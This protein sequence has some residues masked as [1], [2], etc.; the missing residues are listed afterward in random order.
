M[1]KKNPEQDCLTCR[2]RWRRLNLIVPRVAIINLGTRWNEKTAD[3]RHFQ[4][5][6]NQNHLT[7]Y[8]TSSTSHIAPESDK[9]PILGV[10]VL[11]FS[12][13]DSSLYACKLITF[14]II[15]SKQMRVFTRHVR[16]RVVIS[17]TDP[18]MR[19]KETAKLA[20]LKLTLI[21]QFRKGA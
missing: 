20:S 7:K 21:H 12:L 14:F 17:E 15:S 18:R 2:N 5:G 11:F 10:H 3:F 1:T 4:E 8:E 6:N 19:K 9:V 13:S 16:S